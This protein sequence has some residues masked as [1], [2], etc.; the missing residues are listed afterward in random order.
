M[1]GPVG[2]AGLA[3]SLL[4]VAVAA[5]ISWWQQ[6]GLQRQI[7]IAAARALAQLLQPSHHLARPFH[8]RRATPVCRD[9]RR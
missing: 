4:L 9:D 6:L 7:L 1:N 3:V 8:R 2:W 5:G